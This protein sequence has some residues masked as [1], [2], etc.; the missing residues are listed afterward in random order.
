MVAPVVYHDQAYNA[1]QF[2][3]DFNDSFAN[4]L[5]AI[6]K[7][8]VNTCH[9]LYSGWITSMEAV[10]EFFSTHDAASKFIDGVM[11]KEGKELSIPLY[12][13]PNHQSQEILLWFPLV[14]QVHLKALQLY[15]V[16]YSFCGI[17]FNLQTL[18]KA[19][20][21]RFGLFVTTIVT[22]KTMKDMPKISIP[23]LPALG[24]AADKYSVWSDKF[25][26]FMSNYCLCYTGAML[27]YL[28]R[29]DDAS[30]VAGADIYDTLDMF[31]AASMQFNPVV[32][33]AFIKENK[34]LAA[35]LS[36]SLGG[37]NL[38][39]TDII[40]LLGKGQGW[41]AWTKL[42]VLVNGMAKPLFAQVQ[43]LELKLKAVYNGSAKGF[44]TIQ[45]HNSS[46][47]KTV[48]DLANAGSMID[49][50]C[51][52]RDYLTTLQHPIL[53]ALKDSIWADGSALT[54]EE[55]QQKFVD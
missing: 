11:K 23:V 43:T 26:D 9:Y 2:P 47:V 18:D 1:I 3:G 46:F 28:L 39:A 4:T 10:V 38:Y 17:P 53:L 13:D 42:K 19:T 32:N 7:I 25:V 51:Q 22:G 16:T 12:Q 45:N 35:V 50:G 15:A 37:N 33:P 34:L 20:I 31:L 48:Q 14:Q 44:Q 30:K 55:V 54:L 41:A 29:N 49:C 27:T 6:C 36:C 40:M 21:Q 8:T 24:N 52:N 5:A